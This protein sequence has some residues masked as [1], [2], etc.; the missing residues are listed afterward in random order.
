MS[1]QQVGIGAQ[2]PSGTFS[3]ANLDYRSFFEFLLQKGE[4]YEPIPKERFN[5]E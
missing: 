2:L 5:I 4:A 1:L 3:N